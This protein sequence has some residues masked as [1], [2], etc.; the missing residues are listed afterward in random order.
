MAKE[1]VLYEIELVELAAI[2]IAL[3]VVQWSN[4]LALQQCARAIRRFARYKCSCVGLVGGLA[5]A[6]SAALT[7]VLGTAAPCVHDEF[8]YLLA[9]DTFS[10]GRLSNPPHP[11]WQHFEAVHVNQQPSY[12]SMYPPAQGLVLAVGQT[13]MGHPIAGVWLSMGLACAAV[14]WM[15]QAWCPPQWAL[16]GGLLTALRFVFMR[17]PAVWPLQV[18][19]WSQSYWGGAMALFGG[20]LLFGG[21]RRVVR[22]GYTRDAVVSGI[23]LAILAN[24]RPFE[25][26]VACVP[27][28]SITVFATL[29]PN[30]REKRQI[31]KIVIPMALVLGATLVWMAYYN[32]RTTGSALLRPY[33]LSTQTYGATPI[34]LLQP[35]N[36]EPNYRHPHHR[37]YYAGWARSEFLSQLTVSGYFRRIRQEAEM[38]WSF[39]FGV[40]LTIPMIALPWAIRC[41]HALFSVFTC[42][43][44]VMALALMPWYQVHYLSPIVPLFVYL[45][46][47]CIRVLWLSRGRSRVVFKSLA[48]A[49]PLALFVAMPVSAMFWAYGASRDDWYWKRQQILE[50]LIDRGGKHLVLVSAHRSPHKE[51]VY[52]GAD[53]EGA[54]VIWAH[55]MD[56]VQNES[57]LE[58]YRDRTVWSLDARSDTF[59]SR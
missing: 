49:I 46:V 39:Y 20:A 44:V 9:A 36:T 5:F 3:L 28:I 32:V 34:T 13:L 23:G 15:L 52:N 42:C 30:W 4:R 14:C 26:F 43:L 38:I 58:H 53:L 16:L 2:T 29:H 1:V 59:E 56:G 55:D 50:R 54:S 11:C 24:S 8:S 35:L 47:R 6:A 25:G 33:E 21:L 31:Q 19:Y 48:A 17:Y 45:E 7:A 37:E 12:H 27:A 22:R 40:L 18:G 10:R 41:R 51:W 57:L